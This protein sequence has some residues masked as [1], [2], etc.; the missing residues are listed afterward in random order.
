MKRVSAKPHLASAFGNVLDIHA[1]ALV[2]AALAPAHDK[3]EWQIARAPARS[4]LQDALLE[5]VQKLEAQV[6]KIC[7]YVSKVGSLLDKKESNT[8]PQTADLTVVPLVIPVDIRRQYWRKVYATVRPNDT[9]AIAMLITTAAKDYHLSDL[10]ATSFGPSPKWNAA[11]DLKDQLLSKTKPMINAFNEALQATRDGFSE[12]IQRYTAVTSSTAAL[13]LLQEPHV[14]KAIMS[15][16]VSPCSQLHDAA[17]SIVGLAFEVDVREDCFRALLENLPDSSLEG[18]LDILDHFVSFTKTVPEACALA[19]T[20]VRCF[21][22]IISVLCS[23]P[24]GLLRIPS[25]LRA[26]EATGP[27]SKMRRLWS[28]MNKAIAVLCESTPGWAVYY[29]NEEMV[30][31]MR[32][33]IIFG[34]EMVDQRKMFEQIAN[35]RMSDSSK[36]KEN[37]VDM[38]EYLQSTLASLLRWLRLT[39]EELLYQAFSLLDTIF[40]C[41]RD[42]KKALHDRT[43]ASMNR[44]ID[45]A[46]KEANAKTKTATKLDPNRLRKLVA[47]LALFTPAKAEEPEDDTDV[48][49]VSPP[50]K[51]KVARIDRTSRAAA[52]VTIVPTPQSKV[53]AHPKKLPAQS[54]K[55]SAQTSKSSTGKH[56]AQKDQARLDAAISASAPTFRRTNKSSVVARSNERPSTSK[57]PEARS[58]SVSS[59]SSHAGS[60]A[61]SD[62]DEQ[63]T[64]VGLSDL[65]KK[66]KSPVKRKAIEQPR[67]QIKMLDSDAIA[68]RDHARIQ[69]Q[70]EQEAAH[71]LARRM[72]PNLSGLHRALLSW[73]YDHPDS[74]PPMKFSGSLNRIPDVFRD[75]EHYRATLEPLALLDCWAQLCQSK[76][77][78]LDVVDCSI[79]ARAYVDAWL[80]LEI[81]MSA[82]MRRD[83]YLA[84]TDVI[85][86]RHPDQQVNIIAKVESA[87]RSRQNG[88]QASIRC[89]IPP[90]KS[91][92]GLNTG[93]KWRVSK[94]FR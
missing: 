86:L 70:R 67:R 14:A 43:L 78:T 35:A 8:T 84:D 85:L 33:A 6:K 72:Q 44:L 26:K 66:Q 80:D 37:E 83:W 54:T 90:G 47:W 1:E 69:R 61:D 39:D 87:R 25:F 20:I 93:S 34:R 24:D 42:S 51:H 64:Q 23:N 5:D 46:K 49:E 17:Q 36:A 38:L 88:L 31:W 10:H 3:A 29:S 74:K 58:R 91:D 94:I 7:D 77:E 4:F 89:I 41:F 71:R 79:T 73:D 11:R 68:P 32:D 76:E 45:A 9:K 16:M 65:A 18:I 13:E 27:A 59:S 60:V 22:D 21:T 12:A 57:V 15:L 28:S 30:V 40:Q 52:S 63:E 82:P 2:S 48:V 81:L 19:T 62:S 56:Q 55:S 92:P 75:P 50:P 53:L